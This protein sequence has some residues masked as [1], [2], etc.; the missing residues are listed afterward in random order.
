MYD[1]INFIQGTNF[2]MNLYC[3]L[4][5]CF[6]LLVS[7]RGNVANIYVKESN[8]FSAILLFLGILLFSLTSFVDDDFFHYYEYMSEFRG[9]VID[10]DNVGVE[11]FYQYLIQ[12]INGDYFLFRL[13]VWGGGL[14]FTVLATRKFGAN[15][16]HTLFVILAGFIMTFS[17]ARAT[18]AMAVFSL[19]V[20]MICVINERGFL[21][22]IVPTILGW[23]VVACSIYFHRSLLPLV[24]IAILW[25]FV[26]GKHSLTKHAL[27]LFPLFV[28]VVALVL[29][30][31]FEELAMVANSWNDDETGTLDKMEHY[32]TMEGSRYN[33]NGYIS[34]ALKYSSFYLPFVLIANAF[35]SEQVRLMVG[36]KGTRLFLVTYF[37]FVLATSF[38]FIG[39]DSSVLFYRY[40][41]MSFI[42]LSILVAYM[43][44][45]GALKKTHYLWIII[46]L[47]MNS[48]LQ[49]F[50]AVYN[51]M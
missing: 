11:T 5:Y 14:I 19:G 46:C 37:I 28:I 8:G 49:L 31:G 29:K 15:V 4:L 17:Y 6:L 1:S 43:K 16:Y 22:K 26:P 32:R 42:P 20:A 33:I 51:Q 23:I 9:H 41:F 10:D 47:I 35:R 25:S 21:K 7:L 36:N 13:V 27:L 12:F 38:L 3:F 2:Y 45:V 39:F 40:L 30:I 34:L 24:A 48:L 18:L 44:D 50:G